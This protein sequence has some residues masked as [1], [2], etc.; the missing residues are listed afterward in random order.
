VIDPWRSGIEVE[1]ESSRDSHKE[2]SMNNNSAQHQVASPQVT[3][4]ASAEA[5]SNAWWE[6]RLAAIAGGRQSTRVD[7]DTTF[8]ITTSTLEATSG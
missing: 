1:R 5:G 2:R 3:E 6:A 4:S 8:G 7:D